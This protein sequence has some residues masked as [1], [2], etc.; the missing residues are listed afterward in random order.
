MRQIIVAVLLA[1][2]AAAVQGCATSGQMIARSSVMDT[3]N[4][5][6]RRYAAAWN[7]GDM[8]A[9]GA[10]FTE[11]ARYVNLEGAFVRGRSAIANVHGANRA[12]QAAGARMTASL[13]GARAI[14]DDTIVSVMQVRF[15]DNANAARITLTLV[16]REGR[17]QIAQAQASAL[18]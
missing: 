7:G 3:A 18:T 6:T 16:R 5:V 4:D 11:D 14:T 1:F 15:S 13:E 10:L 17:W 2:S 8:Y 12:R 9:F